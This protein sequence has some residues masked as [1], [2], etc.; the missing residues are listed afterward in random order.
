MTASVDHVLNALFNASV[1]LKLRI[2]IKISFFF[3]WA[4]PMAVTGRA[5]PQPFSLI[6]YGSAS[7]LA[8]IGVIALTVSLFTE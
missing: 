1:K 2:Q 3:G 8:I 5:L 7:A 4:I 6:F